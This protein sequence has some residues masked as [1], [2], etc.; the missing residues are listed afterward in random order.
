MDLAIEIVPG[1][2]P[3]SRAPYR[4]T[5]R[6]L[7]ELKSQ[8]Q[9]LLDKGFIRPSVSP[10]GSPVLFVK[11]KDDTL[12]MCIDYQKINKVTVKNKYPLPII[13]IYLIS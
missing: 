5:P 13:R 8:L 1:I 4:M 6:E 10:W 7:K 3:M 12:R 11:K 2:V 9:E